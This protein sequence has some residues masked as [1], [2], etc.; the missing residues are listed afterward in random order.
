MCAASS[1][2]SGVL[3]LV[4]S[5][6]PKQGGDLREAPNKFASEFTT[7]VRLPTC[8]QFLRPVVQHTLQ[9]T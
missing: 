2:S 6:N 4:Q 1:L 3:M 9:T 8:N 5:S 7:F